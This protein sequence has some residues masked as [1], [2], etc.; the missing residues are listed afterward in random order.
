MQTMS[1]CPCGD[2]CVCMNT[3]K[4]NDSVTITSL[5]SSTSTRI[6]QRTSKTAD[7][8]IE[9]HAYRS[10]ATY[11]GLQQIKHQKM[12]QLPQTE[13]Y[14]RISHYTHT[15]KK[16]KMWK[17]YFHSLFAG[18]VWLKMVGTNWHNF[19]AA[20]HAEMPAWHTHT[21]TDSCVSRCRHVR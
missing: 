14:F 3:C 16:N 2:S 21:H 17:D 15:Q 11:F 10:T 1:K 12:N 5:S 13:K 8:H 20:M 4:W 6:G 7:V 9:S 18:F 19:T